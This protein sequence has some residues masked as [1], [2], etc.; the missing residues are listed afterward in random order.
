MSQGKFVAARTITIF[1][2]SFS[3]GPPTPTRPKRRTF[4]VSS[5]EETQ[6]FFLLKSIPS[7]C[8]RSSALTRLL[9]SCSSEVPLRLH[10]E[11]ISSMK[12]VVGA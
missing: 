3:D 2:G 10:M 5:K 6:I 8:I 9:A 4:T 7:I 1:E 11:S 12:M